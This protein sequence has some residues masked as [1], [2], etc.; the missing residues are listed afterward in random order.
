MIRLRSVALVFAL[1][2]VL[3][4]GCP[5]SRTAN[6][7]SVGASYKGQEVELVVPASM[8]LPALWEVTLQEWMTQTGA[9]VRWSEYG[10]EPNALNQKLAGQAAAGGRVV[11]F[12]LRDLTEL[13]AQLAPVP[14][15]TNLDLKDL[16][17]GLRDRVVSRNRTPIA[18]PASAPVFLCYYRA[19]LLRQAGMKPPETWEDY[20]R[21]VDS[22]EKWAPGLPAVEPL[23][24]DHRAAFF[25][26]RSL[27]HAKHPENYS[28]WFDLETGKPQ[29]E[30]AGFQEAIETASRAWKKMPAS[31]AEL[32]PLQCRNQIIAGKAALAIGIEPTMP[33]KDVVRADAIEIGVC[34][35]PGTRRAYNTNSKRWDSQ[36]ATHAPALCGFDGMAIGIAATDSGKGTDAAWNLLTTLAGDQFEAN[37]SSLPKSVCRESQVANAA[38]WNESGLTAEESSRAVDATALSLRDNQVVAELPI[39][40]SE[41]YRQATADIVGKLVKNDVDAAAAMQQLQ[42]AF[43]KI[44]DEAGAESIRTQYRRGLGLPTFEIAPDRR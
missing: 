40:N 23:A 1:S 10:A 6:P 5:N 2:I 39:A 26:A 14:A 29:F 21:L 28:V 4:C 41:R 19:D 25:F 22:L 7:K 30:T 36:A 27:A 20:Q 12:P 32:T 34:R 13:D 8:Q 43:S 44:A 42:E 31:I 3:L 16:L 11:L 37:W 18:I 24:P 15:G 33:T 9:T 38:N 17:K 35:L